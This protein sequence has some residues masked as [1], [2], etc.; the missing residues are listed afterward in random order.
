[1]ELYGQMFMFHYED[2]APNTER[3]GMCMLTGRQTHSWN[4]KMG[5]VS[6]LH[7][8]DLESNMESLSCTRSE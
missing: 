1:M 3:N 4:Y 7:C 6:M 5:N 2:L 8:G